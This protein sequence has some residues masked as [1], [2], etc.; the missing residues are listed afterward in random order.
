LIVK[1]TRPSS[2]SCRPPN[3]PEF[4]PIVLRIV[5]AVFL[6]GVAACLVVFMLNRDRRWLR[7]AWKLSRF[8]LVI[9]LL[10]L[11]LYVLERVASVF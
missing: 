4:V 3:S 11:G 9:A 7:F 2:C 8:G 1:K 10:F 5:G 6:T